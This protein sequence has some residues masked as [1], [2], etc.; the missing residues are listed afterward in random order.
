MKNQQRERSETRSVSSERF[1]G[2]KKVRVISRWRRGV[3][4]R[5]MGVGEYL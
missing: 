5:G 1:A 3:R 2:R 4:S